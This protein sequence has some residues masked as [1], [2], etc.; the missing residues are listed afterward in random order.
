LKFSY[1]FRNRV[2]GQSAIS[3]RT[4]FRDILNISQRRA[5]FDSP[6]ENWPSLQINN[7][8]LMMPV[9]V[10]HMLKH[11]IRIM[12]KP[13]TTGRFY[14]ITLVPGSQSPATRNRLR[15]PDAV[16]QVQPPP[17]VGADTS[18]VQQYAEQL[19]DVRNKCGVDPTT[20]HALI[21]EAVRANPAQ[22]EP[23]IMTDTPLQLSLTICH[24]EPA[25]IGRNRW[26]ES[27][28]SDSTSQSLP[29]KEKGGTGSQF[30][31]KRPPEDI[32]MSTAAV[33]P[34]LSLS[35]PVQLN[36]IQ[37]TTPTLPA[38]AQESVVP[39]ELES[40]PA[41]AARLEGDHGG[42]RVKPLEDHQLFTSVKGQCA[43]AVDALRPPSN[44]Q[45]TSGVRWMLW[46]V[47]YDGLS[48]RDM[49]TTCTHSS[50]LLI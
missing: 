12:H 15:Q 27:S 17:A 28:P 45:R 19:A 14:I 36:I 43:I 46:F 37:I 2:S 35:L 44:E 34:P 20:T 26:I 42:R 24:G 48:C 50:L 40:T 22:T 5:N 49:I 9:V 8:G 29:K 18:V 31:R 39:I 13:G 30:G 21:Q 33:E 10:E 38:A 32:Q 7:C 23:V 16:I 6:V 3:K 25:L 1:S 4:A 11:D 47:T 41:A